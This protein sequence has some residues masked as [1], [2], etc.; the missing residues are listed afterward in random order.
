MKN[1]L[2]VYF[3]LYISVKVVGQ[4]TTFIK[5]FNL[6][7]NNRGS[8]FS[9]LIEKDKIYLNIAGLCPKK[10]SNVAK[11]NRFGNIEW[12][13][14]F[15]WS[16]IGND[17]TMNISNNELL[18]SSH[19]KK[20]VENLFQVILVNKNSGDSLG[21]VSTPLNLYNVKSNGLE[22]SI[23]YKDTLLFYGWA[24]MLDDTVSGVIQWIKLNGDVGKFIEYRVPNN[25]QNGM[26]DITQGNDGNLYFISF[27]RQW[28]KGPN[29]DA[30][31]ITV[32]NKEGEIVNAFNYDH[33]DDGGIFVP[34]ALAINKE[35]DLIFT[36]WQSD[37]V[38]NGNNTPQLVRTSDA[39]NLKWTYDWPSNFV[40]PKE[41][42]TISDIQIAKNGDIIGSGYIFKGYYDGYLFRMTED[43]KM[44]WERRY[45]VLDSL[46]DKLDGVFLTNLAEDDEGNII[47][48]GSHT[49]SFNNYDEVFLVKTDASGC[50]E[51]QDCIYRLIIK[52]KTVP[53]TDLSD[54]QNEIKVYPNPII[55]LV[56]LD[57]PENN[58]NYN[59]TISDIYGR[60][61]I[62]KTK[63]QGKI[64]FDCS[65]WSPGIYILSIEDGNYNSKSIKLVK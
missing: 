55:D 61:I 48:S 3:F 32:I 8:S 17:N 13:K 41:Q 37:A 45:N 14:S 2:I 59:Y 46:D 50:I 57:L 4:P 11:L 64:S 38:P 5:R 26:F 40:N 65:T 28:P 6:L 49:N 56:N 39:G 21:Y 12:K 60:S 54:H 63:Q 24:I 30:R 7:D 29:L 25:Y 18:I 33:N 47:A 31:R 44:L 53:V 34:M 20:G 19:N 1:H 23:L 9:Q 16:S 62:S 36:A 43:G 22:G 52:D 42:F 27:N 51:G 35:N 58:S 10:C 15:P